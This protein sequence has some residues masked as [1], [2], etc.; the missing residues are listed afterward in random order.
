MGQGL[1]HSLFDL[2]WEAS[3]LYK[4]SMDPRIR[5]ATIEEGNSIARGTWADPPRRHNGSPAMVP[6][7]LSMRM[8][9]GKLSGF[10]G[11]K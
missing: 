5:I 7:L 11:E 1:T 4:G 3:Q 2:A 6:G 8:E 9:G 10:A